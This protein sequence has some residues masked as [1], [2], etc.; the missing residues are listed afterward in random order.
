MKQMLPSTSRAVA[1]APRVA[2]RWGRAG[3]EGVAVQGACCA[4]AGAAAARPIPSE[5]ASVSA[6]VADPTAPGRAHARVCACVWGEARASMCVCVGGGAGVHAQLSHRSAL[7]FQCC[8]SPDPRPLPPSPRRS[9]AGS[10]RPWP[11]LVYQRYRPADSMEKPATN[12]NI[13]RATFLI[14]LGGAS[15][16][17]AWAA[18]PGHLLRAK[19]MGL[20]SWLAGSLLEGRLNGCAGFVWRGTAGLPVLGDATGRL[21]DARC[22]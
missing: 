11:G 6:P 2:G 7:E 19:T 9:A 10:H 3:R 18:K 15:Q 13:A 16:G 21:A 17:S 8:D 12:R 4:A 14:T 20:S 5:S 1:A 22:C